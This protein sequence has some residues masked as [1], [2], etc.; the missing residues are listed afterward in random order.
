[1]KNRTDDLIKGLFT[2]DAELVENSLS[3]LLAKY[4]SIRDF[5]TRAPKENYYHGFMN[6]LLINGTS[7][8]EEHKSNVESGDGY[9]DIIAA[10][11]NSDTVAVLELKQTDR[12]FGARLI[13]AQKA[14]EQ[15]IEKDYASVYISDPL[16]RNVYAYGICFHNKSCSVVVKKLK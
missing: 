9:V 14:V 8:I 2:G 16:V 1:M 6:G 13:A 11:V 4:V 12:P 10:S 5:S 15:I 3:G 7:Y